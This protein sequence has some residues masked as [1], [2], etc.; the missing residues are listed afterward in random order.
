MNLEFRDLT[1]RPYTLMNIT[2][3]TITKEANEH[4][5]LLLR[6]LV[7]EKEVDKYIETM[8]EKTVIAIEGKDEKGKRHILFKGIIT[9]ATLEAYYDERT[10]VIEALS[11]TYAMD[12][13]KRSR[14]FQDIASTYEDIIKEITKVYPKSDVMDMATKGKATE[15]IL[16]QYEETDWAFIKR[17]ATHFNT[18]LIPDSAFENPKY[19]IGLPKKNKKID[20]EIVGAAYTIKKELTEYLVRKNNQ[21]EGIDENNFIQFVI[22][23]GQLLELGDNVKW[24]GRKYVIGKVV[25]RLEDSMING[26]YTLMDKKG[27]TVPKALNTNIQGVVLYGGILNIE[28]DQVKVQLDI[29][30]EQ[31]EGKAY[32]FPFATVYASASGAGW[33]CMPEVGDRVRVI[34]PDGDESKA[35]CE[36]AVHTGAGEEK[37]EDPQVKYLSTRGGKQIVFNPDGIDIMANEKVLISLTDEGGIIINSDK[38]IIMEAQESIEINSEE[39][40]IVKG[41]DEVAFRQGENEISIKDGITLKGKQV[42]ME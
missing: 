6:G 22:R 24:K 32:L 5:H 26:Y 31:D 12:L 30:G 1:I 34:F 8:D 38:K 33:Y 23:T 42:N 28:K 36:S 7:P 11:S 19:F 29:D 41:K 27:L 25:L 2:E 9:V 16:V 21:V 4:S 13:T 17:L 20:T 37:K 14:S 40:L 3:L 10:I 39:K 15:K 35:Y 18:V